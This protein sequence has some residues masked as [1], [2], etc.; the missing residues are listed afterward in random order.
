MAEAIG[1]LVHY[2]GR[3]QGVGFRVTAEQIAGRYRVTG[4]VRNLPD[5]RVE[6]LA[7]G[8]RSDVEAFL[9]AV[10]RRFTRYIADESADW[11]TATGRYTSFD[12]TG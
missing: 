8:A 1:V 5:G 4:T 12:V 11:Q 3:V 9:A 2:S 6:L 10:R 7:E